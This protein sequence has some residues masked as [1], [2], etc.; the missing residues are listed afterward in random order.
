MKKIGTTTTYIAHDNKRIIQLKDILHLSP[1]VVTMNTDDGMRM[2]ASSV[3]SRIASA[4]SSLV[5]MPVTSLSA[6][7][8]KQ[9]V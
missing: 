5:P 9:R 3:T 8:A 6:A 7:K 1:A 2:T 4:P